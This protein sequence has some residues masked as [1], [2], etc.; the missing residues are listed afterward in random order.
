MVVVVLVVV[1]VA[2]VVRGGGGILKN[3]SIGVKLRE[4]RALRLS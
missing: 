1:V 3:A 4:R 2:V